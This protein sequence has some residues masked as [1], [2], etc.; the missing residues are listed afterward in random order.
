[1]S[2]AVP[3]SLPLSLQAALVARAKADPALTAETGGRFFDHVPPEAAFPYVSLGPEDEVADT[4]DCIEGADITFQLDVWSRAAGDPGWP[5]AK[6]IARRLKE[7]FHEQPIEIEG[8]H[9]LELEWL[10]TRYLRDPDGTTRHAALTF[11]AL[12]EED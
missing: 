2:I 1:M 11:R 6:R 10:S 12:T 7:L 4:A 8:G 5:E 9:V 3:V